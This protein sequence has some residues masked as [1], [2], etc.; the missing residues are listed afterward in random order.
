[1]AVLMAGFPKMTEY[2]QGTEWSYSSVSSSV[3]VKPCPPCLSKRDKPIV[4]LILKALNKRG[5]WLRVWR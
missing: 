4:A 5:R 2:P 3:F 1:M